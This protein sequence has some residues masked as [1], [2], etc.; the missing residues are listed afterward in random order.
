MPRVVNT[1]RRAFDRAAATYDR[2]DAMHREVGKRLVEHLDPIRVDPRR[3]VDL[4]CGTGTHLEAISARFPGAELLAV[5]FSLPMLERA[6]K[7]GSW[8]RRALARGQPA[9]LCADIQALPLAASSVGLAVSNL[10]LQWCDAERVFAEASRILVKEGL[11]LF[12]TLGPDTL[13]ELRSAFAEA[14]AP[15]AASFVDMHDLG[16]AL[17]AAGFTQPVMEMEI[18]TLEYSTLDALSR[19]LHAVGALRAASQKSLGARARWKRAAE[20][21]DS[22]RRGGV[23]PATYEVVYGHAWKGTP[24]RSDGRQVVDFVRRPM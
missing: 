13:R 9:C 22:R 8:W 2:A 16:D 10:A 15:L 5:D 18:I 11:L 24:R 20:A 1:A 3:V 14:G 4:G 6:R 19:D 17:V 12:S 23:L 7:H 21:Y